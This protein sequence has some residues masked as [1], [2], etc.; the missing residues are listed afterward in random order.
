MAILKQRFTDVTPDKWYYSDIQ[1]GAFYGLLRGV[2]DG[3][4][5]NPDGTATRAEL[6]STITRTF[7]RIMYITLVLNGVVLTS[8]LLARK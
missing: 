6:G 8:I 2:D 4:T 3:A 1:R 5:Y 7:E